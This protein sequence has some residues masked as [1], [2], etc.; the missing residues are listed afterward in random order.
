MNLKPHQTTII[1]VFLLKTLE[2]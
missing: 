1:T 2:P